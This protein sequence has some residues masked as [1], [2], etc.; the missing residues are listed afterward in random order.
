V[1]V[2]VDAGFIAKYETTHFAMARK[3]NRNLKGVDIYELYGS[4][5]SG[6]TDLSLLNYQNYD[7][8][9]EAIKVNLKAVL[10]A[11]RMTH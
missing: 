7:L 4:I 9:D 5:S 10:A 2:K 1:I 8:N 11:R 6:T 3:F